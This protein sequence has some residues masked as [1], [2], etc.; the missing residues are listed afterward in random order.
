MHAG[1][2][3]IVKWLRLREKDLADRYDRAVA[4]GTG[5]NARGRISSALIVTA[6]IADAIER[7]EH[8]EIPVENKCV[9]GHKF[10]EHRDILPHNCRLCECNTER[11][12]FSVK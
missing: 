9:C 3:R 1:D 8:L 7:G 10:S 12:E 5:P 11:P 6:L 4:N 2:E